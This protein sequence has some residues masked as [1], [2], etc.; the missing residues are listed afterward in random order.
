MSDFV[1][2]PYRMVSGQ[3]MA[4]DAIYKKII[5]KRGVWFVPV[6]SDEPAAGVQF[7]D[8]KALHSDGYG[9]ATLRFELEDGSVYLAKGPWHGNAESLFQ[10]TGYDIRDK[11]RTFV[12]LSKDRKTEPA[13]HYRTIFVDVV[14]QDP[15]G[16]LIGTFDRWKELAIQHPE[17]KYYYSESS[18]GSCSGPIHWKDGRPE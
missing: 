15:E 17:A 6:S 9:G 5:G 8:P 14:Y 7:H 18:T 12:V 1:Q 11:Y 10:D 2:P 16:G 4:Q 13:P 3:A